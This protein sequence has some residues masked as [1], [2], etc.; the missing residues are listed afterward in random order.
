[1]STAPD[2]WISPAEY[3]AFERKAETRSEYYR[4]EIFAMAGASKEHNLVN[5]NLAGEIHAALKGQSCQGFANELRVKVDRTGL[6]TYPDVIIVCE[7]PQFEDEELDTLLNPQ[8]IIEV[9]SD[10]TEAYDRGKKFS[11]YR[12]LTSLKEYVLV[13]Q[14][15]PLVERYSRD[16]DGNWKIEDIRGLEAEL[17]LDSVP[18]TV[19]LAEIYAR[20]E[21]PPEPP[22]P[23]DAS[24]P[25]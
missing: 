25:R 20:V 19:K 16:I 21:F 15:E 14:H 17:T 6:Y 5:F 22:H 13:S 24:K 9:L 7:E 3:L 23:V 1:M 10:S 4:G 18:V 2:R 8:V 12:Q 11:H